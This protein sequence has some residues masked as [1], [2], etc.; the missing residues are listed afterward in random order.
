VSDSSQMAPLDLD[1]RGGRNGGGCM[2]WLGRLTAALLVV[3]MSTVLALLAMVT[4]AFRL[5]YDP[6][7]PERLGLAEA[8]ASTAEARALALETQVA[9][10]QA[11]DDAAAQALDTIDAQ[12]VRLEAQATQF[13]HSADA[14]ATA[15]GEARAIQVQVAV[16]ATAEAGRAELLADLQRRSE[17]VERFL[18]RLGDIADD[19]GADLSTPTL[20]PPTETAAPPTPSATEVASPTPTARTPRTPTPDQP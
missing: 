3:L 4:L 12:L 7:T 10:L 16:F 17:R 11:R 9:E 5:G 20:A 2:S 18:Q 15:M 13:T 14:M 1:E 8:A 19:T 6:G